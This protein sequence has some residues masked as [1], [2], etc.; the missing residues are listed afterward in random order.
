MNAEAP[1]GNARLRPAVV[2]VAILAVIALAAIY[3]FRAPA[4]APAEPAG[5]AAPAGTVALSDAAAREAGLVVEAARSVTRREQLEAPGVLAL[6]E[7]RTARIGSPVD[8][9][10]IEVFVEIGDRVPQGKELAH[11]IGPIVHDAWA[12]YRKAVA[13]RRTTQTEL[14]LAVQADER[15]R[16]LFADKAISEQEVPRAGANRVAAEEA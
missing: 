16:R 8:G 5:P 10:V 2:G 11:M 9:K 4:P 7:R 1:G 15:A 12:A 14:K 3:T 6:D 13:E